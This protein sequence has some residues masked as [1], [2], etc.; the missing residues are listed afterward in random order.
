MYQPIHKIT[1]KLTGDDRFELQTLIREHAV[2][3]NM[4][5]SNL[6][7]NE[8]CVLKTH[9]QAIKNTELILDR[10]KKYEN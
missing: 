5:A 4:Y 6:G 7:Q 8:T 10:L 1:M 2:I 9:K 3:M